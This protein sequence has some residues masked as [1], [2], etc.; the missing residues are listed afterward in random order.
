MQQNNILPLEHAH[1]RFKRFSSSVSKR[2]SSSVRRCV[3][4]V[5]VLKERR[6]GVNTIQCLIFF[7]FSLVLLW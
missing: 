6:N 1:D 5:V 7:I 3:C 2:F 4:L